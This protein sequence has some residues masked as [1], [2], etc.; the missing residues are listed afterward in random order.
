MLQKMLERLMRRAAKLSGTLADGAAGPSPDGIDPAVTSAER[1]IAE[2]NEYERAGNVQEACA[3]YR[4]AVAAAPEYAK[5]HLNLGIGLEAAGDREAATRCYERALAIDPDDPY[6]HYN[7]GSA[8]YARGAL[9][10]AEAHF[11]RSLAG[12]AGFAEARVAL[13]NVQDAR[14]RTNLAVDELEA[15]LRAEPANFGALYNY[16]LLL[17]RLGRDAEAESAL[18]RAIMVAPAEEPRIADARIALCRAYT[19]R[20]NYSAATAQ[21]EALLGRWPARMDVRYDYAVLLEAQGRPE[22]AASELRRMMATDRELSPQ[23]RERLESCLGR[24][25][26]REALQI[27][28]DVRGPAASAAR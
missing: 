18:T 1:L 4:L 3:R 15:A 24:S 14:G 16:G 12:K 8:L 10:E 6:A 17:A 21:V 27:Y 2:G 9:D 26:V 23:D 13:A 22:E 19:L 28:V 11:R 7:L 5:A 20:R 25:D